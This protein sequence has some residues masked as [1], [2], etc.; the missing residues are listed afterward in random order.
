MLVSVHFYFKRFN[1]ISD[2]LN[3]PKYPQCV[4]QSSGLSIRTRM[5][6]YLERKRL[7]YQE[8]YPELSELSVLK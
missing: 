7:R 2:A 8:D 4:I 3:A 1:L 5:M 6:I